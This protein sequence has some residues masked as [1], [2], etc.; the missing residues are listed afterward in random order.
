MIFSAIKLPNRL[1]LSFQFCTP[2][3]SHMIYHCGGIDKRTIEKFVKES[4][5]S[6]KVGWL[7]ESFLTS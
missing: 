1:H 4:Q 3:S 7:L 2:S 5:E 6:G